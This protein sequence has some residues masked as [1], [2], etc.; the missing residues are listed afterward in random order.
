[1]KKQEKARALLGWAEGLGG[2]S[3]GP[4]ERMWI[5]LHGPAPRPRV[6]RVGANFRIYDPSDREKKLIGQQV[7]AAMP[8]RP[9]WPAGHPVEVRV[10]Y[11]LPEPLAM[12]AWQLAAAEAEALLPTQKPDASNLVKQL[13]DS[14]NMLVYEDD[15]QITDLRVKKRWSA[16]SGGRGH[17][18]WIRWR[19]A[20]PPSPPTPE[21]VSA[22]VK[23]HKARSK[24]EG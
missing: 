18:V 7:K 1:M 8:D 10:S 15:C 20:P 13:E 9:P 3:W 11:Y 23:A 22:A 2:P 4:W 17:G 21:E 12:P 6:R 24:K 14:I 16:A 5:P 19:C